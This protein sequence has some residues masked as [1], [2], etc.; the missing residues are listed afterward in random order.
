MSFW[1]PTLSETLKTKVALE[2][3]RQPVLIIHHSEDPCRL[4][5]Y[6]K[7]IQLKKSFKNST[8]VEFVGVVGGGTAPGKIRRCSSGSEHGFVGKDQSVVNAITDWLAGKP[9]PPKI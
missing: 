5:P 6:D 7:A 1:R 4:S 2:K 3:I 8:S 9:L